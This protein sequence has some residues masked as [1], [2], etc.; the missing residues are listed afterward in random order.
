MSTTVVPTSGEI[1][2]AGDAKTEIGFGITF[3]INDKPIS[4]EMADIAE[5]TKGNFQFAMRE[6][7]RV[8]FDK[9]SDFYTSLRETFTFLPDIQWD[10][11]PE[12]IKTMAGFGLWIYG[13]QIDIEGGSVKTFG[14]GVDVDFHD[15]AVPGIPSLKISGTS[16][17]VLYSGA[18]Q[19]TTL[20]AAP[21]TTDGVTAGAGYTAE[22]SS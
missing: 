20:R 22:L 8:G 17:T 16:L 11:L 13:F 1:V 21:Q 19:M 6:G 9:L 18:T 14:I 5:I 12:P 3:K 15:W 7:E 2:A 10:T 4:L